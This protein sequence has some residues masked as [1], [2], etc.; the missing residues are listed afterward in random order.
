MIV[1]INTASTLGNARGNVTR[2]KTCQPL[3]PAVVAASSNEGSM[4]RN[5]VDISK[6]TIGIHK[7]LSTR[8]M[9]LMEK[10]LNSGCPV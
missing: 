3:L 5:G 1:K 2:R 6:N 4:E 10:I 9:P 7:K 8:T